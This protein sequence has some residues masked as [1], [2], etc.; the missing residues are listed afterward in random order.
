MNT[1]PLWTRGQKTEHK[2]GD[3]RYPDFAERLT[4]AADLNPNVPPIRSGRLV[5]MQNE[6]SKRGQEMTL[7]SIRKWFSGENRPHHSRGTLLAE[8][9]RCDEN[10]LL[11]GNGSVEAPADRRLRNAMAAGSVNLVAGMLQMDGAHVAFP[12]EGDR[13]AIKQHIDIQAIIRGAAYSFHVVAAEERDEGVYVFPVPTSLENTIPLGVVRHEG[14]NFTVF[15]IGD[16]AIETGT[17]GR[18]G[19]VEVD[20]RSNGVRELTSFKDRL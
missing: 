11:N 2:P 20:S 7:E 15:E 13:F 5:F 8:I 12:D 4:K 6:L 14:F 1:Q 16:L 9:L 19:K 17:A 10:W 18:T 3:V